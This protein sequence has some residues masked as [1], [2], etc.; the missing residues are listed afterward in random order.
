MS[1]QMP[2]NMS[3]FMTL[4]GEGIP[5]TKNQVILMAQ[6]AQNFYNGTICASEFERRCSYHIGRTLTDSEIETLDA[7]MQECR[8]AVGATIVYYGAD[9][10]EAIQTYFAKLATPV[11]DRYELLER[12]LRDIN[13]RQTLRLETECRQYTES[14]GLLGYVLAFWSEYEP[15]T[16]NREKALRFEIY[17]RSVHRLTQPQA[18]DL[19]RETRNAVAGYQNM[20][21]MQVAEVE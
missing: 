1:L 2:P 6:T 10:S 11:E 13:K 14:L 12:T 15:V 4:Y 5:M 17:V 7:L 20:I 3:L 21:D 18:L 19:F 16:I 9:R 8:V